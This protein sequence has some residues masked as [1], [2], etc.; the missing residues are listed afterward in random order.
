MLTT[1][2]VTRAARVSMALSMAVMG[3]TLLSSSGAA[4][5]AE[6]L[7]WLEWRMSAAPRMEAAIAPVGM[8]YFL[9]VATSLL[10]VADI[11]APSREAGW[12]LELDDQPAVPEWDG[13][14][15]R[16]KVG[17]YVGLTEVTRV[18]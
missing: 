18:A 6:A 15:R 14:V 16:R 17:E 3:A 10:V 12:W 4:V 1:A 11:K 5:T 9:R 7:T 13:G 2:G 8:T